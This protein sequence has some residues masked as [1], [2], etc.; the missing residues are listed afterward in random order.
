MFLLSWAFSVLFFYYYEVK[1]CI[2]S[3][4]LALED[5]EAAGTSS[6]GSS[7]WIW[8]LGIFW[9]LRST[10]WTT[11]AVLWLTGNSHHLI[12]FYLLAQSLPEKEEK[13]NK[14]NEL[15]FNQ[16]ILLFGMWYFVW[17]CIFA[18]I[19][20]VWNPCWWSVRRS[21][22]ACYYFW[23]GVNEAWSSSGSWPRCLTLWACLVNNIRQ[24]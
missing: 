11:A 9:N 24:L 19:L 8:S 23:D 2:L 15:D 22:K 4:N 1:D 13:V 3:I 12:A 5:T 16:F 21:N 17:N 14:I 10:S 7:L 18:A 20:W 6:W